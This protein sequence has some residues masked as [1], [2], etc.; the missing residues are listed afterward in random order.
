MLDA[1]RADLG[2]GSEHQGENLRAAGFVENAT[3]LTTDPSDALT[4]TDIFVSGQEGYHTFRI[5]SLLTTPRGTLL[6]TCEG[7]KNNRRD[8]G[9]VD[10]VLKRSDN[11]GATWSDL[12]LIHEEGGNAEITIGNP[13]PV[14][15]QE[16]GTIWMPFCRNNDDVFVMSS[17]DDGRT[18]S[19]PRKITS[20]VK[21][22]G[23]GWYATGPGVGI[24]LTRGQYNGRL[25]IPCD[26]RERKDNKWVTMS[27]VFYSDDHG[28][29]WRLGGTVA[30]HTN[31]CQVVELH[32]GRLMIN[33]RNLWARDGG[34]QECGGK[35]AVAISA[36]GGD[37]WEDIAFHETLIE[38]ICQASFLK[39]SDDVF[40]Q[41]PLF[42]S[43]PASAEGRSQ[44]TIRMSTDQAETWPIARTIHAGPAAYSCLTILPDRSLGCLYEAGDQSP[45]ERLRYAR[46]T[47]PWLRHGK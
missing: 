42:F 18:W 11:F 16:T 40:R 4:Q 7:R 23:W 41:A 12:Q 47:I 34:R 6:A 27:H 13:C 38:P 43:N 9:D 17:Q 22:D 14:V 15:D 33:M 32:D 44:L 2:D 19:K 24:Q 20:D 1:A 30:D 10:L 37:S 46:F 39:H 35:R 29:T 8:Q 21:R 25:V 5:P 36:D 45:Y 31:E 3:T 28:A 26:H